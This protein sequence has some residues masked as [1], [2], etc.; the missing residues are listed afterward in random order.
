MAFSIAIKGGRFVK[1][2]WVRLARTVPI[3]ILGSP[4]RSLVVAGSARSGT[5]WLA[6]LLNR[7]NHFRFIFEPFH[8]PG[9][10]PYIGTTGARPYVAVS[11][12]AGPLGEEVGR[13][14]A[15]RFR[16]AWC[17][18]FNQKLIATRRLI[19]FIRAG[20][21][22]P[23]ILRAYHPLGAVYLLRHPFAVACSVLKCGWKPDL[24]PYLSQ[25]AFVRDYL[26]PHKDV[27]P[28]ATSPFTTAVCGWCI[29]NSYLLNTVS[30][31]DIHV[32]CYEHLKQDPVREIERIVNR[33][34]L[35]FLNTE[36]IMPGRYSA[37][38]MLSHSEPVVSNPLERWK[39][40]ISMSQLEK[41]M[42]II[43]GFGL[44]FL[45]D[46]DSMPLINSDDNVFDHLSCFASE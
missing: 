13:V 1:R 43:T 12:D 33:F 25:D 22:L 44:D 16:D 46:T 36:G 39:S 2:Q 45:Y 15:G 4:E 31:H 32:L 28:L 18:K 37:S 11:G 9:P 17:D 35:N 19:K 29:E 27:L 30:K 14:L 42:E 24:T 23:W 6:E 5:T 34:E 38:T 26:E 21:L 41:G 8:H 20:L 40:E 3:D 10:C 7:D